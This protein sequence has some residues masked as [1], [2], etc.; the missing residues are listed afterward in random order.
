MSLPGHEVVFRVRTSSGLG[1]GADN[2]DGVDQVALNRVRDEL[3]TTDF[4]GGADKTFILGLKGAEVPI[5]GDYESGDTPQGRLFTA[6]D[7]G[8]SVWAVCL[9][10]GTAGHAVE[11]KVGN[12]N[13]EASKDGKVRFTSTLRATGA[14]SAV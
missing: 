8:S 14:V 11:C 13:I 2:C 4:A 7:D 12:I 10:N 6:H 3:E 9:W 1:T 5:Q